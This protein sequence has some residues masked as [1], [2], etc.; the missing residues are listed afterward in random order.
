MM[1]EN[2]SPGLDVVYIDISILKI[3]EVTDYSYGTRQK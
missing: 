3:P 1:K 2:E